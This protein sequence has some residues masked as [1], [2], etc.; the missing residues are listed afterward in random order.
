[1]HGKVEKILIDSTIGSSDSLK[2][3]RA[4]IICC[5][6]SGENFYSRGKAGTARDDFTRQNHAVL[7]PQ[8]TG[9]M[10]RMEKNLKSTISI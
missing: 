5:S 3:K 6:L 2:F 10:E 9:A 8:Y 7:P 1:M 4:E